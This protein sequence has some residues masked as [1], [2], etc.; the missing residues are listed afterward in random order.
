MRGGKN[1]YTAKTLCGNWVEGQTDPSYK[2]L[3]EQSKY[4][5]NWESVAKID[6]KDGVNEVEEVDK[7]D[8][9]NGVNQV[10]EFDEYDQDTGIAEV[11]EIDKIYEVNEV[12]QIDEVK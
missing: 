12:G 8:E 7:V 1:H 6:M 5:K 11:N 10:D 9:I 3:A 4:D 2:A